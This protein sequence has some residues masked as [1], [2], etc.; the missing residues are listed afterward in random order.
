MTCALTN[1]GTISVYSGTLEFAGTV[2]DV[3]NDMLT[4]GTWNVYNGATLALDGYTIN[5][6]PGGRV[7]CAGQIPRSRLSTA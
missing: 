5:M 2:N 6:Q 1:T 7:S 4:E 3:S